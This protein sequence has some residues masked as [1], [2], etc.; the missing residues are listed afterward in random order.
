MNSYGILE[1]SKIGHSLGTRTWTGG[2]I[3]LELLHL[4]EGRIAAAGAVARFCVITGKE[5]EEVT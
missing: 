2:H 5:R 4:G 3:F 1:Y